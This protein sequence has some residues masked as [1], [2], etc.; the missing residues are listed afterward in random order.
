MGL[1]AESV[2]AGHFVTSTRL[3]FCWHLIYF[4]MF[5][6]LNDC[7]PLQYHR[8]YEL[9]E[10]WVLSSLELYKNEFIPL[11]FPIFSY[12]YIELIAKGFL[13]EVCPLIWLFLLMY[14]KKA[15]AFFAAFRSYHVYSRRWELQQLALCSTSGDVRIFR[16]IISKMLSDHLHTNNYVKRLLNCQYQIQLCSFS[17]EL[18]VRWMH[19]N[20]QLLFPSKASLIHR[21]VCRCFGPW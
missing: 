20:R 6:G 8:N 11:L 19:S 4:Q 3:L 7:D 13:K 17:F 15:V 18:L 5:V 16:H 10:S 14:I 9:L 21:V 12:F 1:S 2:A